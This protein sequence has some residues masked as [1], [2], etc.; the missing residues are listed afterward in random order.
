MGFRVLILLKLLSP[1]GSG[2]RCSQFPCSSSGSHVPCY[3]VPEGGVQGGTLPCLG[4]PWRRGLP[5]SGGVSKPVVGPAPPGPTRAPI[6]AVSRARSP[7]MSKCQKPREKDL[8]PSSK[9]PYQKSP[10]QESGF[11]IPPSEKQKSATQCSQ[12]QTAP[13][14]SPLSVLGLAGPRSS[15]SSAAVFF[16]Q[17]SVQ[18]SSDH[19]VPLLTSYPE[20]PVVHQCLPVGRIVGVF[21]II[22]ESTLCT[23]VH[24]RSF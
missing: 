19:R 3:T 24:S 22:K 8:S 10:Y 9:I 5:S 4:P 6:H 13:N 21:L 1:A 18:T 16:G 17:T 7:E 11:S 20:L 12:A 15:V 2:A 14:T 23:P